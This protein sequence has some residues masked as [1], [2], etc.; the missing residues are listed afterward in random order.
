GDSTGN[1]TGSDFATIKYSS[2]GVA[3][4]TN[5]YNGI[6]NDA[7]VPTA[8]AVDSSGNV[9]VTGYSVGSFGAYDCDYLTIK[10]SN[11]GVPLWI[12]RYDG[13]ANGEDWATGIAVDTSGNV[14]VTGGSDRLDYFDDRIYRDY[15]TI[16]YSNA[17]VTLWVKRFTFPSYDDA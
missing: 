6:G 10:Y 11:A 13:P 16:K 1:G 2:A 4:W 8:I 15:T 5:R 7:D 17:G 9:F 14:F 12:N 3:L